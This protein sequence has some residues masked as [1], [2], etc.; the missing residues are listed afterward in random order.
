MHSALSSSCDPPRRQPTGRSM[1]STCERCTY[2]MLLRRMTP[3]HPRLPTLAA[4]DQP[5]AFAGRELA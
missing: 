2:E 5:A 3:Q 4:A 1:R